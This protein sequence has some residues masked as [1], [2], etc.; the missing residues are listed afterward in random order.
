LTSS[1]GG[2]TKSALGKKRRRRAQLPL[3]IVGATLGSAGIVLNS[4][5]LWVGTNGVP[6]GSAGIV[7]NSMGMWVG[8][9]GVPLGA[10]LLLLS[11]LPHQRR[12]II[13]AL[14][15][16]AA[17]GVGAIVVSLLWLVLPCAPEYSVELCDAFVRAN[18]YALAVLGV[19]TLRV[20][21]L[22]LALACHGRAASSDILMINYNIM[23]LSGWLSGALL[24]VADD[25]H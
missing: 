22:A 21:Y 11:L 20:A 9:N 15:T 5:G 6:L 16:I 10:W 23:K 19:F 12:L 18:S 24:Q 4:M 3:A 7:L 14:A 17:I 25:C 2:S 1:A 13:V 8:A